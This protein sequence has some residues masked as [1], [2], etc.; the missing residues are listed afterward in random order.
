MNVPRM[1]DVA[2]QIEAATVAD[3]SAFTMSTFGDSDELAIWL[4]MRSEGDTET[5]CKTT[6]CIA[7]WTVAVAKGDQHLSAWEQD[8]MWFQEVPAIAAAYLG[9]TE[10]EADVLFHPDTMSAW[11]DARPNEPRYVTS[12]RA[13]DMIRYCA[14]QGGVD[15]HYWS[16]VEI[17]YDVMIEYPA[18]HES[19][20]AAHSIL[21]ETQVFEIAEQCETE[22]KGISLETQ[23]LR[24]GES[25]DDL[26]YAAVYCSYINDEGLQ[27][28]EVV[29]R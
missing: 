4:E 17:R 20:L 26:P 14:A 16:S 18:G 24:D 11:Y 6:A 9:L 2:A 8:E 21:S 29:P 15:E 7:G 23:P 22:A 19:D 10:T 3:Q 1:F 28:Y 25:E 27:E 12:K 5:S 13:V